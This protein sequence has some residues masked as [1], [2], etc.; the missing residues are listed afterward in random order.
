MQAGVREPR[1]SR[2]LGGREQRQGRHTKRQRPG[3]TRGS[4]MNLRS[5]ISF[6]PPHTLLKE[7]I[8]LSS[9]TRLNITVKEVDDDR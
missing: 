2:Q 7:G 8:T 6:K 5:G 4:S 1:Q 3:Q 9:Q